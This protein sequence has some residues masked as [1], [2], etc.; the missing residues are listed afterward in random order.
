[1][2]PDL[3]CDT[4]LIDLLLMNINLRRLPWQ[5]TFDTQ[6]I[7]DATSDGAINDSRNDEAINEEQSIKKE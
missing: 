3:V 5:K 6:F 7:P 4:T 2:G 1:M